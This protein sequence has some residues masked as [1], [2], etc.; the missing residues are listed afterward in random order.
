MTATA[1]ESAAPAVPRR[2]V[3][4]PRADDRAFRGL[5]VVGGLSAFLV[6]AGIFGYIGYR[7]FPILQFFGTSFV[8][9][10][11][12]YP[13]DG[14][15][16]SAVDPPSYG[17]LPMLWGSIL[18]ALIALVVGVPLGVGVALFITFYTR[19]W[20]GRVLT[21]V[22][23]VTAAVPSIIFGMWA[24]IVLTRHIQYWGGLLNKYL[25]FIPIFQVDTKF[26]EQSPFAAG[27][28]L[29]VMITPIIAA[30]AREVF[31]QVPDELVTGAY[32]LGASRWSVI[33]NIVLPF[34]RSGMVGG[35]MLGMG[36]ALGE[37]IAVFFVLNLVVDQVNWYR[38]LESQG[39][40]VASLIV[41][42]FGEADATELAALFGAGLVLFLLTLLVNSLATV[43][44]SRAGRRV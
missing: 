43:I 32:A 9:G 33:R 4:R 24:F 28:V 17:L 44:A 25:G 2:I 30:V 35:A 21:A 1:S 22:V 23:D 37:T 40:S 19:G 41:S 16:G 10:S 31:S 3:P 27:C 5:L 13:G 18:I 42:R 29:T 15:L 8:T 12:W 36:R 20:A 7:A 34:G 38:I 11:S 26:Y 6:L 39:G 14:Q